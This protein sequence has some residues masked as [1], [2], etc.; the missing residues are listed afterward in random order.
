MTDHPVASPV[1][2]VG[3]HRSGTTL[4]RLM[5]DHHP[6]VA[7][8]HEF[9]FTMHLVG[10]RGEVP[11]LERFY[12]HLSLNASFSRSGFAIDRTLSFEDLL[13]S[14]LEQRRGGKPVV[15]MTCHENFDRLRW[16]W[17]G[18]RYI[19][20]V[21]D[22]R[23][24]AS[25]V[26]KMNWSGNVWAAVQRWTAA[27]RTWNRVCESVPAQQ[28]YEM[29]FEH[30]MT[31]PQAELARLCTFLG[32]DFSAEMLSYPQHS[33]YKLPDPS[34]TYRW[35]KHMAPTS[36]RLVETQVG[37]LLT[38]RGY[39]PSGLSSLALPPWTRGLLQSHNRAARAW[40]SCRTTG[41][42]LTASLALAR[43]LSMDG[44]YRQLVQ[45]KIARSNRHISQYH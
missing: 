24:V 32:L 25:S 18:A 15:G 35:R 7:F 1:F 5:L 10:D 11:E 2:L 38:D 9:E 17:P 21:R 16:F 12:E 45:E 39:V 42:R 41:F 36:V 4:L 6:Q 40:R 23:D 33:N 34:V 3:A 19:H 30:L 29:R 14:F 37:A 43:R 8:P 26:V 20:L 44:W 28:R 13:N 27:E 31:T 22:P